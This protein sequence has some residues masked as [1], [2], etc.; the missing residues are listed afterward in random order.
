MIR[1]PKIIILGEAAS[2]L[3]SVSETHV[4]K[5]LDNLTRGRTIFIVT[6]RLS[7][8]QNA[9]AILVIKGGQ[10]VESGSFD[11]LMAKNGEFYH[12]KKMQ[13]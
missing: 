10:C 3:D 12:L 7:T 6:H 1:G 2:A 4:Q 8:V 9:D 5:A 11:E 13:G